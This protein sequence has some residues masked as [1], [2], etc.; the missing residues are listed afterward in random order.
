ML[1]E[2]LALAKLAKMDDSVRHIDAELKQLPQRLDDLRNNVQTL[3]TLLAQE[4]TQLQEAES[5]KAA[6]SA[7]LQERGQGLA[8]A[9]RNAAQASNTKEAQAGEREIEAN[10]RAIKERED[11]LK[12]IGEAIEAKSASLGEREKDFEG[13]KELLQSEEAGSKAR[14]EE[15]NA[16]HDKLLGGREDLLGKIPKMVVKRYDRLRTGMVSAVA[17]VDGGNCTACRMKIPAQLYIDLQRAQEI[18][19][20]PHCRRLMVLKEQT[21]EAESA[22]ASEIFD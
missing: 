20:C 1:D 2:L 21:D 4:R 11:E 18:Q 22:V 17:V 15:L 19:Q 3:E 9:R 6:Q 14:I 7:E 5:L 8:R 10:R 13:A 16:E 12:R